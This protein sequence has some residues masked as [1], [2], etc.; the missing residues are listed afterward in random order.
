MEDMRIRN[1][2]SAVMV[3]KYG[4]TLYH[5][6]SMNVLNN[7]IR[8]DNPQLWFSE[9][10]F[11]NDKRELLDFID[12]L[13]EAV[14]KAISSDN[15]QK[16]D[17]FFKKVYAKIPQ[18][19]PY[20]FCFSKSEDDVAQWERYAD[21]AKGVCLEFDTA[22]LIKFLRC[23]DSPSV[24]QDVFYDY[25][26]RQHEHTENVKYL[27]ETGKPP[28]GFENEEILI[29]NIIATSPA[30]KHKSF[31]AEDE[32]RAIILDLF[33]DKPEFECPSNIIKKVVKVDVKS[34]CS[35]AGIQIEDLI[36]GIVIAPRS[37]QNLVVLQEYLKSKGYNK[38]ANNVRRSECPLR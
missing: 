24:L 22:N 15:I 16:Y 5:Y 9:A 36:V 31:R 28:N 29:N 32:V 35:K 38:L 1:N 13:K 3:Q 4:E 34:I 30:Y 12:N 18:H 14:K 11:L 10:S 8:N 23:M 26:T 25:D 7:I 6:T 33:N 19:Y 37:S 21:N 20:I 17:M 27:L 2:I